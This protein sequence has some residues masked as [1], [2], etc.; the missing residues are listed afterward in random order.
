[1]FWGWLIGLISHSDNL[2]DQQIKKWDIQIEAIER[3]FYADKCWKSGSHIDIILK[4][5]KSRGTKL[6]INTSYSEICWKWRSDSYQNLLNPCLFHR[7]ISPKL[8]NH[9]K[10]KKQKNCRFGAILVAKENSTSVQQPPHLEI[11]ITFE[12]SITLVGAIQHIHPQIFIIFTIWKALPPLQICLLWWS[13]RLALSFWSARC[14]AK[15]CKTASWGQNHGSQVKVPTVWW[16]FFP[17]P[18]WG[19]A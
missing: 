4:F 18:G 6:V 15:S 19:C 8:L 9:T 3:L 11:D 1:M 10:G 13:S 12:Q 2:C 17:C 7:S 5:P 14:T 16:P